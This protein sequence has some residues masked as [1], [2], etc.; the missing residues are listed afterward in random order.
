MEWIKE[1]ISEI[2]ESLRTFLDEISDTL[3][4]INKII[5]LAGLTI[6][7]NPIGLT[8]LANL[9]AGSPANLVLANIGIVEQGILTQA[10]SIVVSGSFLAAFT[11]LDKIFN[12]YET[13]VAFLTT[14]NQYGLKRAIVISI[15]QPLVQAFIRWATTAIPGGPIIAYVLNRLIGMFYA[16][17]LNYLLDIFGLQ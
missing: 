16:P 3:S 12:V 2:I 13:I 8:L 10:S 6:P 1:F 5:T 7:L 11:A 17:V 14:A 4:K 9:L 15:S